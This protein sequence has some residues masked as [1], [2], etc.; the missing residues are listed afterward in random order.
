L[1]LCRPDLAEDIALLD[2]SEMHE[3]AHAIGDAQEQFYQQTV[4]VVLSQYFDNEEPD[5]EA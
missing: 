3:L 1:A 5:A 2:E 4:S